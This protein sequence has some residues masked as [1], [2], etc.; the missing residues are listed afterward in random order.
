MRLYAPTSARRGGGIFCARRIFGQILWV[1][2]LAKYINILYNL[3]CL[4]YG[5]ERLSEV[6][7]C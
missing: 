1:C 3:I 2:P 6:F 5:F 4:Y 7:K